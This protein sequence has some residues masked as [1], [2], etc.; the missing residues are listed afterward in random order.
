MPDFLPETA[1]IRSDETWRG[2]P[3]AP[4]LVDRR[5]EITGPVDRKMVINAVR[6]WAAAGRRLVSYLNYTAWA[7]VLAQPLRLLDANRTPVTPASNALFTDHAG[8]A[9]AYPSHPPPTCHFYPHAAPH[10]ALFHPHA[11]LFLHAPHPNHSST[12]A[13]PPTWRILRVSAH[14]PPLFYRSAL[15]RPP[16]C[17]AVCP[18][19][20]Q[21]PVA[22][23]MLSMPP[24]FCAHQP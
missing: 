9:S 3:P 1:S 17:S 5:V 14:T 18:C 21:P 12:A 6:G 13:P 15:R 2:A 7:R 16:A 19:L 10:A 23:N 4:G 11:A 20:L 8:V 24:C 22:S